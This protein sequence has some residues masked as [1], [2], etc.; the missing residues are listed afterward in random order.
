MRQPSPLGFIAHMVARWLPAV[1]MFMGF[2]ILGL[3][4]INIQAQSVMVS[5]GF[6]SAP[7]QC[8]SKLRAVGSIPPWRTN[9][10]QEDTYHSV[11]ILF[12]VSGLGCPLVA[13]FAAS[14]IHMMASRGPSSAQNDPAVILVCHLECAPARSLAQGKA[15]AA[16]TPHGLGNL[17]A[18][19]FSE[20]CAAAVSATLPLS[21]IHPK[22]DQSSQA[23]LGLLGPSPLLPGARVRASRSLA[24]IY[25][26]LSWKNAHLAIGA[27]A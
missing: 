24:A 21:P 17:R 5:M 6:L 19:P 10:F 16:S 12:V 9:K 25:G 23:A 15:H 14:L 27:I 11:C 3:E 20:G 4:Q 13:R 2:P 1:R 7:R 18:L 22:T 8:S 26:I